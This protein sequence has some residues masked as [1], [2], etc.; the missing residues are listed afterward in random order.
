MTAQRKLDFVAGIVIVLGNVDKGNDCMEKRRRC[1]TMNV[2]R[3]SSKNNDCI[4]KRTIKL[5]QII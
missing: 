2:K 1:K 3:Q 5:G 4:K